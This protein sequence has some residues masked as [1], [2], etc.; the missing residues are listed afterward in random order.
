MGRKKK[1]FT[2]EES[3]IAQNQYAMSYYERNKDIIKE[4]AKK[5]YYER[6]HASHLQNDQFN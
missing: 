3:K 6:A 4:K 1:Y 5:R 2:E